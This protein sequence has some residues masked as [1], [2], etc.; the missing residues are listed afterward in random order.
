MKIPIILAVIVVGIISVAAVFS[1]ESGEMTNSDE[2]TVQ[3]D[4]I[5]Q[6]LPLEFDETITI[7]TIHRDSVKMTKRYQPLADYVAEKLSDENTTYK[8]VVRI[9]G[10]EEGMINSVINKEMDIFFDSPL[11]GMKV[12]EQADM[13]P[14]L[15]SW[16]EGYR[17]YHSVFIVPIESEITFDDLNGKTIVFE[18]TESTSGYLLPL[19]HLQ[20][21]GYV[22]DAS[23]ENITPV[24]SLDDENTPIW[25]LEG[26]G[27]V[28]ATSNLDFEDI[29][30]NIKEKVKVIEKTGSI[31]RQMVFV[32]NHIEDQ[33]NLKTIL[34]EMNETPEALEILGKISRTSQF[35]EIDLEKDL[36]QVR[37]I[38]E[39]LR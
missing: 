9:I 4:T 19:T 29:P 22:A 18:D 16:K 17:E 8:G 1:L 21:A 6:D 25:L 36:E 14:L 11:I 37:K 7:G 15:L 30:T 31:P 20:N 5:L 39:S 32:G 23:S 26:R 12:A 28:G 13:N 27:D 24:F 2:I 33:E 34:L 35:S 3:D 38:L 10:T